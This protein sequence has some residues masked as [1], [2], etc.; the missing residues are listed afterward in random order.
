M[1]KLAIP[2][3]ADTCQI[4]GSKLE[5]IEVFGRM[6]WTC[7]TPNNV[8]HQLFTI[9]HEP[10]VVLTQTERDQAFVITTTFTKG[11]S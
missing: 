10:N 5:R 4:C 8:A 11:A 6:A 2:N 7:P 9:R 3:R 1:M